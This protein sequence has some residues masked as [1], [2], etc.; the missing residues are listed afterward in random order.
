MKWNPSKKPSMN[1]VWKNFAIRKIW[2]DQCNMYIHS[3]CIYWFVCIC[4]Y[5]YMQYTCWICKI[6]YHIPTIL[7][8]THTLKIW[9]F[10]TYNM[11]S[12][13]PFC[14]IRWYF[15]ISLF[16]T[17]KKTTTEKSSSEAR[18][19]RQRKRSNF[20]NFAPFG[21]EMPPV[22]VRGNFWWS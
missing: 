11:F 12:Y 16:S 14:S 4:K 13:F 5:I 15:S 17:P 2:G 9:K 19:L 8:N 21:T 7:Y 22:K 10:K 3:T 18:R 1:T 20:S 6:Y